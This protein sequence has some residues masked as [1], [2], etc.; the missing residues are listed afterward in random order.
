MLMRAALSFD[1]AKVPR[2]LWVRSIVLGNVFIYAQVRK[3]WLW[4]REDRVEDVNIH[5]RFWV[6]SVAT[7]PLT[8]GLIPFPKD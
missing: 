3:Q 1:S 6:V 7:P 5:K 2:A 8:K 4:L